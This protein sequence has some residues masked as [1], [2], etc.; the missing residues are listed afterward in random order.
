MT[1]ATTRTLEKAFLGLM[2]SVIILQGGMLVWA[3][4]FMLVK[5]FGF[6]FG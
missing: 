6:V 5:L 3:F 4:G 2:A 1:R